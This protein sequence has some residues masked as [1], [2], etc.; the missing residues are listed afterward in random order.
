MSKTIRFITLCLLSV[1]T[2]N[3]LGCAVMD[4]QEAMQRADRALAQAELA[5]QRVDKLMDVYKGK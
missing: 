5:N 2:V 3:L 4:N 1:P